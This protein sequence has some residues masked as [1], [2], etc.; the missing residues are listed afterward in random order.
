MFFSKIKN[1]NCFYRVGTM[2]SIYVHFKNNL[3][4]FDNKTNKKM[5]FVLLYT[6]KTIIKI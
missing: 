4:I 5:L 3:L 6:L 2:Y 1:I